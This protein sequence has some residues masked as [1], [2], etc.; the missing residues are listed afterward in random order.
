MILEVIYWPFE[1]KIHLKVSLLRPNIMPKQLLNSS[2][3][4]FKNPRKWVLWPRKWSKGP[5][6]R[7][8]IW[9]KILILEVIYQPFEL[10]IQLVDLLR[11]KT[12]P[13]QLLNN[14]KSTFKKSNKRLFGLKTGQITG[15]KFRKSVNFCMY[16]GK[17][18]VFFFLR[19][20][21]FTISFETSQ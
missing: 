9:A 13:K 20:F 4:T 21:V 18:I 19:K 2:K 10:K 15:T 1:L 3:P 16:F 12:I 11:P 7:A 17:G 5:S 6:Q 8:K 14:S